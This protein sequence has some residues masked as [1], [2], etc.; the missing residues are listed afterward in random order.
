MTL[1]AAVLTGTGIVIIL[2]VLW[3]LA[4]Y[5]AVMFY[6]ERTLNAL[7]FVTLLT[8]GSF[9]VTGLLMFLALLI[10]DAQQ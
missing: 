2:G 3:G 4:A 10:L 6:R 9:A 7:F 1:M 8:G 5:G